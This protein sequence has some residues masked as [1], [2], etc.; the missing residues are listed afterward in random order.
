[1]NSSD[2]KKIEKMLDSDKKSKQKIKDFEKILEIAKTSDPKKL[3][4][5]LEIYNNAI[6]D[7]ACASALFAQAFSQLGTSSA[8]HMSMGSTLVKY[9]E[10]MTKS[11]EQLIS[12]AQ[13]ISKEM[14]SANQV[15]TDS[16]FAQIEE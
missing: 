1:M 11:N 14:E 15:N 8:D 7:R 4:L 2:I 3:H 13:I 5:W 10:R 16:I 9:L 12:L 6:N